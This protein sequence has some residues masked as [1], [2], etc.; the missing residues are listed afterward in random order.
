MKFFWNY[1]AVVNVVGFVLYGY[2]KFLAKAHQRRIPERILLL[3]AAA[4]GSPGC[5][6]A[7]VLFR[8]KTRKPKFK[9]GVPAILLLQ[10]ALAGAYW[11][12]FVR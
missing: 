7:M 8:H 2:D 4:G 12:Y 10:L 1:L 9:F 3:A 11:Y 6:L 5:W